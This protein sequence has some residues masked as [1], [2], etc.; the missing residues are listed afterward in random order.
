MMILDRHEPTKLGIA[1][2][3]GRQCTHK[4]PNALMTAFDRGDSQL[5]LFLKSDYAMRSVMGN[6]KR[7]TRPWLTMLHGFSQNAALFSRQAQHFDAKFRV[8][9]PE[10]LG[11]GQ[12]SASGSHYTA[13]AYAADVLTQLRERGIER[14]HFWGTHTGTAVGLSLAIEQPSLIASLTLEAPVVPGLD[15]PTVNKRIERARAIAADRGVRAAMADWFEHAEWFRNMRE[16]PIDCRA[17]EQLE[18]VLAFAGQPLLAPVPSDAPISLLD[19]VRS[20]RCPALIYTGSEDIDDFRQ[21]AIWLASELATSERIELAGLG[22]F[23]LWEAPARVN[24]RVAAF[25]QP[26]GGGE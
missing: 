25:L 21:A 8:F 5:Q 26:L 19:R 1:Q 11:H 20:I 22:G 15:M 3:R 23:P 7:D 17:S 2:A 13:Q 4:F 16:A 10:L 24:A 6:G 9:C 14:T 12:R 18:M